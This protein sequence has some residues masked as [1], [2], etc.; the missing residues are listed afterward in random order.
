MLLHATSRAARARTRRNPSSPAPARRPVGSIRPH[1]FRPSGTTDPADGAE[2]TGSLH[3]PPGGPMTTASHR[4]RAQPPPYRRR[5]VRNDRSA[6]QAGP[7]SRVRRRLIHRRPQGRRRASTTPANDAAS[8]PAPTSPS[9]M[10]STAS[11]SATPMI[12][13]WTSLLVRDG[14]SGSVRVINATSSGS[15]ADNCCSICRNA[16]AS[17]SLNT[18]IS[19]IAPRRPASRPGTLGWLADRVP[20]ARYRTNLRPSP[21]RS[22]RADRWN[23]RQ[24]SCPVVSVDLSASL[25][26]A[27]SG[28]LSA[29]R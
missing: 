24:V 25:S 19:S 29:A 23:L 8:R 21:T 16:W 17:R 18:S 15:S 10:H 20:V 14:R 7:D 11:T 26:G 4:S 22:H 13:L 27:L 1:G 28:A 5:S 12:R 6:G 9:A 3:T 2:H